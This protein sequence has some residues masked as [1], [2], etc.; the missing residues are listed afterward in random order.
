MCIWANFSLNTSYAWAKKISNQIKFV[1]LNNLNNSSLEVF[2]N[3]D[4]LIQ[5][6]STKNAELN[7]SFNASS[8]INNTLLPTS[9][10]I[11]IYDVTTDRRL[12]GI[13]RPSILDER[14][15]SNFKTNIELVNL[16]KSSNLEINIYNTKNSFFAS[17]NA[18]IVIEN[19]S[20]IS[21]TELEAADCAGQFGKCQLEYIFQNI[22]FTTLPSKGLKTKIE[23]NTDG[24]YSINLPLIR[25]KKNI[26]VKNIFGNANGSSGNQNLD[27]DFDGSNLFVIKDGVTT[28][29]AAQGPAGKNGDSGAAGPKGDDG[30]FSGGNN[31]I[32]G[33]LTFVTGGK[34]QDAILNGTSLV[35][36]ST[37]GEIPLIIRGAAAQTANLQEWQN[38][39]GTTFASISSAG[40]ITANNL[41][42]TNTGDQ[43][44]S[45]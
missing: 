16:T 4:D 17:Y 44:L 43:D 14:Q 42:G 12:L 23:Q 26:K 35:T 19:Q 10:K 3:D 32:N 29:V 34:L 40:G 30:S 6:I 8:L 41:S 5:N 28:L 21:F 27:F 31:N 45:S 25:G 15:V 36:T 37:P 20:G 22:H 2:V 1:K 33:T 9:F 13:F 7:L 39:A 24:S 38:S 11:E 18:S